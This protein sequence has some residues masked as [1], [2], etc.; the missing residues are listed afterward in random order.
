[1]DVWITYRLLGDDA[2]VGECVTGPAQE[3]I[4]ELFTLPDLPPED[5]G[6]ELA[7]KWI[8]CGPSIGQMLTAL[9]DRHGDDEAVILR[10]EIIREP[11]DFR[12]AAPHRPAVPGNRRSQGGSR[13]TDQG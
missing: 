3:P 8:S 5:A 4:R 11:A 2:P 7:G 9:R 6:F 13:R 1:M 10:T 12:P